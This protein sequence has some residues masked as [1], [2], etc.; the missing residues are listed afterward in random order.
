MWMALSFDVISVIVMAVVLIIGKW[1]L[2]KGLS[3]RQPLIK[4]VKV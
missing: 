1:C 4:R 3:H 2:V